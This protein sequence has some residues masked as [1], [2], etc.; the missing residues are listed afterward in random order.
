MYSCYI[1]DDELYAVNAMKAYVGE[2]PN[3]TCIGSN[4]DP[5]KAIKELSNRKPPDIIF[6]EVEL[7]TLSGL[8][9]F[10]LLPKESIVIFITS[11]AQFAYHAFENDMVDFLLKPVS[12]D[13]FS[14]SM[15]K[16]SQILEHSQL[17]RAQQPLEISSKRGSL[18][19]LNTNEILYIEVTAHGINM[20]TMKGNYEIKSSMKG[21]LSKL[22][23]SDY[24]R[25]HRSC[26][27]NKLFIKYIENNTMVMCNGERLPISRAFKK[28]VMER[29][30]NL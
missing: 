30:K 25:I 11:H 4:S 14:K 8:E 24:I 29:L 22:P 23:A 20:I 13:R 2:I 21:F 27:V 10:K 16:V 17:T 18:S 9:V 5:E 1:I 26:A 3:L 12:F 7:P 15:A 6:L 28:T 19:R